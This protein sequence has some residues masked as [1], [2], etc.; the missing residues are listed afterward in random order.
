M[1]MTAKK[2]NIIKKLLDTEKRITEMLGLYCTA[3]VRY[4][5]LFDVLEI[6]SREGKNSS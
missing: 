4:L 6:M 3:D 2:L 5:P 1:I